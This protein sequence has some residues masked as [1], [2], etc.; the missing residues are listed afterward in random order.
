MAPLSPS[1]SAARSLGCCAGD[2]ADGVTDEAYSMYPRQ[3]LSPPD[4]ARKLLYVF[5]I[6]CE[7]GLIIA[8]DS[9]RAS[10]MARKVEFIKSRLGNPKEMFDTPSEVLHPIV[11]LM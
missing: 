4:S 1:L 3:F 7:L 10:A 8:A 5:M 6:S 11:C 9:P 2:G